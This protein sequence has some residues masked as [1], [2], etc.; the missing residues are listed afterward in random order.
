MLHSESE[1]SVGDSAALP[2]C[3]PRSPGCQ[4]IPLARIRAALVIGSSRACRGVGVTH[5][6]PCAAMSTPAPMDAEPTPAASA[7]GGAS[8]PKKGQIDY[9]AIERE[10][11]EQTA[12]ARQARRCPA[13]LRG[14]S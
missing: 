12:L 13:L 14:S 9:A 3:L 2:A 1:G 8:A 4:L 7:A 6:R 10:L 5:S 11:E